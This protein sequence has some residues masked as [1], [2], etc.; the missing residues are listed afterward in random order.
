MQTL[1][2]SVLMAIQAAVFCFAM[3][4]GAAVLWWPAEYWMEVR[5]VH[6]DDGRESA[7]LNIIVD[8][9]IS[10]PVN[11]S[12][13]ITIRQWTDGD[14]E[15]VCSM[16]SFASF[17][18]SQRLPRGLTLGR[19]TGGVCHPLVPGRYIMNTTW[20]ILLPGLPDRV[21]SVDSNVFEV[22]L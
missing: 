3:A 15:N 21:V 10:R 1:K 19:W 4:A 13:L 16:R 7:K 9:T 18:K 12:W 14:W 2:A 11:M 22:T 8:R 6:I 17:I 5:K 20:T